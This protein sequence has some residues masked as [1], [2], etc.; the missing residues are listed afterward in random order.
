[1]GEVCVPERGHSSSDDALRKC[2]NDGKVQIEVLWE[3]DWK[4]DE[5]RTWEPVT[6]LFAVN[7]SDIDPSR[8]SRNPSP[9]QLSLADAVHLLGPHKRTIV[10]SG[11]GISAAAG[12]M[13]LLFLTRFRSVE[14]NFRTIV[15]TF[16]DRPLSRSRRLL[17]S[18]GP[19]S[20]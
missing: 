14:T 3:G 11:A 17:A 5:A 20:R 2:L 9:M 13:A 7:P 19:P 8:I 6:N 12:R 4:P 15:P 1:M 10:I 18:A 16:S